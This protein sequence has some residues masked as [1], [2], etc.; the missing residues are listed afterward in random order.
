MLT[1]DKIFSLGGQHVIITGAGG[2]LGYQH[3]RAVL[4]AAGTP[5]MVDI[6]KES[7]TKT[8]SRLQDEFENH[9][10][11]DYCFDITNEQEVHDFY[12]ELR[13]ANVVCSGLVNNAASNPQPKSLG[14][15]HSDTDSL[16]NY[17]TSAWRKELDTG[18]L[19]SMLMSRGFCQILKE[20]ELPGSVVNISSDLGIIAPDQ[21]LYEIEGIAPEFQPKKP[22]TY[23]VV[24]SGLLGLTRYFATYYARDRIRFNALC[25]GGVFNNQRSDF[26]QRVNSLIPLGR[27]A[28]PDEY[29]G[30]LVFMLSNAS[31]YMTGSTLVVDGGRTIL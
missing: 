5:I 30:A 17:P 18:L 8:K 15:S 26:V 27:M 7:L 31:S 10:V 1:L 13:S 21:R 4:S 25:P 12:M 22:V 3:A 11:L 19:G 2:L 24:K 9:Q 16:T 20:A 28:S 29:I 6:S 14:D 23:S